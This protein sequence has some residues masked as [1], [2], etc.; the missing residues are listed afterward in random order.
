MYVCRSLPKGALQ[1]HYTAMLA[2]RVNSRFETIRVC[3]QLTNS[4]SSLPLIFAY[5][6]VQDL[7]IGGVIYLAKNKVMVIYI[8]KS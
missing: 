1:F 8:L 6:C 7:L 4:G 2:F 5:T 3:F